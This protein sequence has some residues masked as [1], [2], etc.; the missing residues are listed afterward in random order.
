MLPL[1]YQRIVTFPQDLCFFFFNIYLFGS[2]GSQLWCENFQLQH[3]GSSSLTRDQ[4][5][6]PCLGTVESQPLDHQGSP[7]CFLICFL[8]LRN[9]VRFVISISILDTVYTSFLFPLGL[10]FDLFSS[11]K[12]LTYGLHCCL[13]A[14]SCL[15]FSQPHGAQP[16]RLLCPWDFPC[17]NTGVGCHFLL[18]GIFLTQGFCISCIGRWGLY[19]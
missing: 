18:Q 2:S 3:V 13:V 8:D 11:S 19:H 1:F 17:K 12:L 7:L 5:W 9:V 15:T 4:I 10:S 14:Q 6:I 16:T